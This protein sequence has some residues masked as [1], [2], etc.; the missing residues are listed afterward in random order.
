MFAEP[1]HMV[2]LL[3]AAA[4]VYN[5]SSSLCPQHADPDPGERNCQGDGSRLNSEGLISLRPTT[6]LD[7]RQV[8]CPARGV[9]ESFVD[10]LDGGGVPGGEEL[11]RRVVALVH[12]GH[13]AAHRLGVHGLDPDV[14]GRETLLVAGRAGADQ[15]EEE[16][17]ALGDQA[18]DR[19]GHDH[20]LD[21]E[22]PGG[23]ERLAPVPDRLGVSSVLP[24]VL[25]PFPEVRFDGTRPTWPQTGRA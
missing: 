25:N 2:M 8:D 5:L 21:G 11:G 23:H 19:M 13:E 1:R 10:G 20:D 16:V 22:G 9:L 15:D 24:N 18:G 6:T 3:T 7:S 14:L 17:R 12:V 4:N